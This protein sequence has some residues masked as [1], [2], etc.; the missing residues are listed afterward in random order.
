M[1]T[2]KIAIILLILGLTI[3]AGCG[4]GTTGA[5]PRTP[6]QPSGGGCG[7]AMPPEQTPLAQ[8]ADNAKISQAM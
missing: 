8:A 6:P 3:L 4:S 5:V 2:T 7:I 1:K